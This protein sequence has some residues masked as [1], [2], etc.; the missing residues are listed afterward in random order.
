MFEYP[1]VQ[2]TINACGR[3]IQG[4]GVVE[5]LYLHLKNLRGS[6]SY[7]Q[8]AHNELIA[9]IRCLGLLT[10]FITLSC[11]DLNWLHM[12]KAFLIAD[13][14]PDEDP[15]QINL[16]EVQR[17]IESYPVVLSRQFSR[18]LD[19]FMKLIQ[20]KLHKPLIAN[21]TFY[22]TPSRTGR[23]IRGTGIFIKNN[24]HHTHYPDPSLRQ[25]ESTIVTIHQPTSQDSINIISIYLPNGS[26]SSFIYDIETLIQTNYRT[27]LI[28]DF[29]DKHRTWNCER[30]NP[31]GMRLNSYSRKL[32]LKVIAP[33]HPTRIR[34]N[35]N[36]IIDFAIARNIDYQYSIKTITDLT[37]D[38][39]PILLHLNTKLN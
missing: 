12:R 23:D 5:G 18:C 1:R 26:D 3:A 19:A 11:N 33:D 2:S 31:S 8:T 20:R 36:N 32:K 25:I 34:K 38:H 30:A 9:F 14:T 6:A 7:W 28:G 17:L 35:S 27:I 29:N 39:L 13:G 21:Y 16:D 24:I 4:Q 15:S 22:S 37:S 10:W